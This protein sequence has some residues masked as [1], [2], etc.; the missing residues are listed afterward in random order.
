MAGTRIGGWRDFLLGWQ[1]ADPTS[2][3][4]QTINI[5]AFTPV[6]PTGA[7]LGGS[8]GTPDNVNINQ[9]GGVATSKGNGAADTGTQRV[10]V[11]ASSTLA[12]GQVS[13]TATAGGTLIAAARTGRISITITMLGAVDAFLGNTGLTSATGTLLLGTK[14]SSITLGTSAAIYGIAASAVSVSYVETY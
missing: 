14:G 13:V 10:A 6:D 9:V 12:T 3:S 2:G 5:P 7:P 1:I 11:A 4:K 8:T